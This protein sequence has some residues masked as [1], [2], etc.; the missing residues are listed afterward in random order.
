MVQVRVPSWGDVD[1]LELRYAIEDEV[2][3]RLGD[4][5]LGHCDGGDIGSGTVNAFFYVTDVGPA[6]ATMIAAVRALGLADAAL[7]ATR[8]GDGAYEVRY[9]EG[10]GPFQL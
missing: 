7:I 6:V 5:G 8:G 2:G 3:A 4:A 9:P 10:A 1:D